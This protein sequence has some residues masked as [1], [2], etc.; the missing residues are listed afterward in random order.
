MRET[1]TSSY[2]DTSNP[3]DFQPGEGKSYQDRMAIKVNVIESLGSELIV[4]GKLSRCDVV[5]RLDPD[6]RV[7]L[8]QELTLVVNTKK[9]HLFDPVSS[10]TLL[11]R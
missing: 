4:H 6:V 7:S 3:K 10:R 9:A 11:L 2:N 5:A 8:D 1:R